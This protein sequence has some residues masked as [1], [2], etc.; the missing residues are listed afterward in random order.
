MKGRITL[1]LIVLVVLLLLTVEISLA[2]EELQVESINDKLLNTLKDVLNKNTVFGDPI[3][4][5][6]QTKIIPTATANLFAEVTKIG[7][8]IFSIE[9]S[10]SMGNITPVSVIVVVGEDIKEVPIRGGITVIIEAVTELL[11]TV[12]DI[13]LI[14]VK[15]ASPELRREPM[16]LP[17][18]IPIEEIPP[19]D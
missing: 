3:I 5:D 18:D 11:Q 4:I 7:E 1:S 15:Y 14:M 19:L 9:T 17:Q 8:G 16:E 12:E 2:E 10:R 13:L 6:E